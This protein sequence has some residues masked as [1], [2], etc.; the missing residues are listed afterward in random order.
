M[1]EYHP[2]CAFIL[3]VGLII[4]TIFFIAMV[5]VPVN[6]Y[7]DYYQSDCIISYTENPLILPDK[8]QS[9][10]WV[11]CDC[12]K[13]CISQTACAKIYVNIDDNIDNVLLKQLTIN[14]YDTNKE[15]TYNIAN[16]E[17]GIIPMIDS[18]DDS[19]NYINKYKILGNNTFECFTNKEKNEAYM[20]NNINIQNITLVCIPFSLFVIFTIIFCIY[21]N[22]KCKFDD[23]YIDNKFIDFD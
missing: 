13:R 15:C 22:R 7:F 10:N 6:T 12:G 1:K 9:L 18:I 17:N 16:C 8:N 2:C 20:E 11:S 19:I 4:S 21:I 3:G 23:G 14:D 5:I